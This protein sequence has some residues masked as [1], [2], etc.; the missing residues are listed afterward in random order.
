MVKKSVQDA[1]NPQLNAELYSSY[2]YLSMSAYC[3]TIPLKGFAKWLRVQAREELEHGMKFY[4]YLVETG[5]TVNL[6]KIDAPKTR[7]NS[8]REVF[9]EVYAHEQKVTALINGLVDLANKEKDPATK[10]FL[11][12]FV[13]EQVEEEANAS[14]ILAQ[15]K[16]SGDEVE[17][18]TSLDNQLGKR[19]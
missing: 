19:E 3:E 1:L 13:K 14:D 16:M 10:Q 12:W 9:E 2:L 7:W 11:D 4:D 18:L 17:N 8:P 5:G 6:T 15:I